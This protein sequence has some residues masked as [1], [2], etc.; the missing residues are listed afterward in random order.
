MGWDA[1]QM[2][3]GNT[4]GHLVFDKCDPVLAVALHPHQSCMVF[5]GTLNAAHRLC[6]NFLGDQGIK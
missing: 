2:R 3:V 6:A 1:V 5:L 4:H